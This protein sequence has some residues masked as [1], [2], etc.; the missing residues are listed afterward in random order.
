MF[1]PAIFGTFAKRT[2]VHYYASGARGH[3]QFSL[4]WQEHDEADNARG[5]L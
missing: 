4:L 3:S 5:R 2:H 1:A